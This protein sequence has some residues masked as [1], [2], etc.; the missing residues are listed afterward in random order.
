[1]TRATQMLE[2]HPKELNVDAGL[3][4]RRIEVLEDCANTCT[5]CTD[6]CLSER[7]IALLAKCIRLNLDCGDVCV[8]TGWVTSRQTEYDANVTRALLEACIAACHSCGGECD[9]HAEHMAALP[10]VRRELPPV[11]RGVPRAPR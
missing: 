11:R 2:T 8:A 10:R 4:A 5:Q 1:M 7:D 9:R 3:R 6:S